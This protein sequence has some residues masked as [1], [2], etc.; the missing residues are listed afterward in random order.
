[1]KYNKKNS[2]LVSSSKKALITGITGQDGSY[3]AELLLN[4]SYEVHGMLRRTSNQN[5]T[6]INHLLDN[7]NK[8]NNTIKLHN[9]DLT[10][11]NNITQIINAL[12]TTLEIQTCYDQKGAKKF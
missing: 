4:K 2:S 11:S 5:H 1:M 9:G 7:S 10:D 3:L 6:R 8:N 12:H